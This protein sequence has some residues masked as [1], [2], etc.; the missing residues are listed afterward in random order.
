MR[1]LRKLGL[2]VGLALLSIS[3]VGLTGCE[4]RG[5][6]FAGRV[7]AN[8][9]KHTAYSVIY[10]EPELSTLKDAIAAANLN[11]TFKMQGNYT[12]FA[13]TNAAFARLPAGT[14]KSLESASNHEPLRNLLWYHV[15]TSDITPMAAERQAV[16]HMANGQKALISS[17]GT[18]I[19]GIDG[20]HVVGQPI[21]CNN[22][23]IYPIDA[24]IMPAPVG[25]K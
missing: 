3:M 15:S 1:E 25:G 6:G 5:P 22:A 20:A 14:L 8:T 2:S 24:V 18:E 7:L 21:L 23:V 11:N 9:G 13:P 19:T 17:N 12:I 10:S 4:Y 16:Q